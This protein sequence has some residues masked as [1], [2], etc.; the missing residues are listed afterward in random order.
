MFL[1]SHVWHKFAPKGPNKKAQGKAKWRFATSAALGTR[2]H[3]RLEA[4]KAFL[5]RAALRSALG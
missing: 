2:I 5:P 3:K 4:L 1:K